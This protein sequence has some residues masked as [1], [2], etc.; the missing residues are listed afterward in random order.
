M[1][2]EGAA[3]ATHYDN[4]DQFRYVCDCGETSETTVAHSITSLGDP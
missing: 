2:L 1:Q 3:P 4:L